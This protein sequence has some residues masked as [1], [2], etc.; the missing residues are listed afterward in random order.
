M[1]S[2]LTNLVVFF[3]NDIGK[4]PKCGNWQK[5]N[6]VTIISLHRTMKTPTCIFSMTALS[7][8][9]LRRWLG[10]V[11]SHWA[12]C[13]VITAYSHM[14][15][16]FITVFSDMM[17]VYTYI[18]TYIYTYIHIILYIHTYIHIYI[19]TYNI[20]YTYIHTYIHT[21]PHHTYLILYIIHRLYNAMISRILKPTLYF[22]ILYP[23]LT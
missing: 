18:H 13:I 22:Y 15:S 16:I 9:T 12:E 3:C 1:L 11:I 21:V 14:N 8:H 2:S 7:S 5:C 4:L 10:V 6:Y 17:A 23:P 19:Y 20:I